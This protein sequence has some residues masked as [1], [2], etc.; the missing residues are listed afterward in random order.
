MI[1]L[2]TAAFGSILGCVKQNLLLF[3]HYLKLE[4]IHENLTTSIFYHRNGLAT[5]ILSNR[6]TYSD[7]GNGRVLL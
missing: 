6:V 2:T 7:Y 5:Q 4:R 3:R 1:T